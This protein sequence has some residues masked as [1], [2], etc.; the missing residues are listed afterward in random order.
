MTSSAALLMIWVEVPEP[1]RRSANLHFRGQPGSEVAD[2]Y[3]KLTQ[4]DY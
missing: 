4:H 3:Q 2:F 1:F